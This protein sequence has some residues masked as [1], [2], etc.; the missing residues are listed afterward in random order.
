MNIICSGA[1]LNDAV[2][3]VIRAISG[4]VVSPI[5]EGIKIEAFSDKITLTATDKELSIIK[6]IKGDIITGG[7]IVVPGRMFSEYIKSLYNED[8]IE[9]NRSG[10]RELEI[11]SGTSDAKIKIL[12]ADEYPYIMEENENLCAYLYQKDLKTLITKTIFCCATNDNRP[13]LKAVFL[14]INRNKIS[15]VATD[16]YQLAFCEKEL[17]KEYD[18]RK[19]LIPAR[20]LN[21]IIKS[22][23][24]EEK[25]VNIYMGKKVMFDIGHTKIITNLINSDYINYREML[26]SEST[27]KVYIEKEKLLNALERASII[28]RDNRENIVKID[29]KENNMK[30]TAKSEMGDLKENIKI[31]IDGKD[32][33]I[34]FNC[35]FLQDGIK[36]ID[37]QIIEMNLKTPS[38][39]CIIKPDEK[40]NNKYNMIFLLLPV[41]TR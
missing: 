16:G 24:E 27:T 13:M 10:E 15:T 26:K 8:K 37:G 33:E 5:L 18:S 28:S 25:L 2:Q 21:E 6:T 11:K 19:F 35:K 38:S 34:S 3:T 32:I 9:L 22:L 40:E 7:T 23:N 41:F 4:K 14:E 17:E 1:E 20:S 12:N 30:V 36:N 31:K 29:I 39:S